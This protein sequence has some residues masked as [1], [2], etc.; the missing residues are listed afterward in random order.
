MP[1]I[2]RTLS[3][4]SRLSSSVCLKPPLVTKQPSAVC[5]PWNF[6]P[7]Y[8]QL[9]T[10]DSISTPLIMACAILLAALLALLILL[11]ACSAA[12][13]QRL[14]RLLESL[15][16]LVHG[17]CPECDQGL[18]ASDNRSRRLKRGSR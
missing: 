15:R 12:A 13:A 9:L 8:P 10:F 16:H 5:S 17:T 3:C 2:T 1:N 7:S 14:I 6:S 11:T 18:K 4:S